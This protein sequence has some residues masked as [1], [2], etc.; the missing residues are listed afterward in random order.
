MIIASEILVISAMAMQVAPTIT[1]TAP[2]AAVQAAS[3]PVAGPF[4]DRA[5][6]IVD[7]VIPRDTFMSGNMKTY[8]ASFDAANAAN[9]ASRKILADN[10][11]LRETLLAAAEPVMR[12]MLEAEYPA[13]RD[14]L[15]RVF[16]AAL[17]RGDYA[18][19]MTFLHSSAAQKSRAATYGDSNRKMLVD[20]AV[21]NGGTGITTTDSAA[22][23]ANASREALQT[24]TPAEISTL[25]H[26]SASLP[27]RRYMLAQKRLQAISLEWA[28]GLATRAGPVNEAI[29]LAAQK[30]FKGEK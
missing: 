18:P 23:V 4:A 16:T 20:Q 24:L 9:P 28:N 5:R 29:M 7:V 15:A 11:A 19:I 27:G 26:F 12:E 3:P 17:L 13:L 6:A 8:V 30:F 10:P 21:A 14:R 25:A 1:Q 2:P 22:L